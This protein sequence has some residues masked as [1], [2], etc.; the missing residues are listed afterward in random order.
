MPKISAVGL[1]SC[2]KFE[3]TPKSKFLKIYFNNDE[4]FVIFT[5]NLGEKIVEHGVTTTVPSPLYN[6]GFVCGLDS[7]LWLR[8]GSFSYLRAFLL[9]VHFF[10]LVWLSCKKSAPKLHAV[11]KTGHSTKFWQTMNAMDEWL[12]TQ[13]YFLSNNYTF[14][15]SILAINFQNQKIIKYRYYKIYSKIDFR[16]I[17]WFKIWSVS[18]RHRRF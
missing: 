12:S 10:L 3:E 2:E 1:F 4:F 15:K 8:K 5:E 9:K 16:I 7:I 13:S 18:A 17:E 11:C 14:G 6:F